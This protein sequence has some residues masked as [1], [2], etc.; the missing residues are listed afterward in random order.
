MMGRDA[1]AAPSFPGDAGAKSGKNQLLEG[2]ILL[3]C[4]PGKGGVL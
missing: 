3:F 2:S 4:K 1:A